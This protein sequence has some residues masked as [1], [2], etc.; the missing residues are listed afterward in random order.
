MVNNC[1]NN[2]P[3][4]K[5]CNAALVQHINAPVSVVWSIVRRFDNPQAYK[6]FIESCSVISG[7]GGVGSVREVH[8]VSGLPAETSI[9]RLDTLDDNWHVLCFSIIGGNH[10]LSNYR[11]LIMLQQKIDEPE[12][13]VVVEFVTVDVPF[14]R[15]MEDCLYFIRNVISW[16]LESLALV[17]ERM[18][19]TCQGLINNN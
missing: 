8:I 12:K 18:A 6:R 1:D 17:S 10:C 7:D 16:N 11:S 15:T 4:P 5:K 3:L 2:V 14:S 9:E 13:T 19:S